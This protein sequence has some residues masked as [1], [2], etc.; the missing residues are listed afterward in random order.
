MENRETKKLTIEGHEFVVKTYA[1][2]REANAIQQ[3]Y[4]KDSKVEI[5][6]EQPK[7]SDFNPFVRFDVERELVNQ[8]VVSLDGDETNI[9][10]R[11][12]DMPSAIYRELVD[13]LDTLVAK[14]N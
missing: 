3:T 14:K 1:T 5:V 12:L 4:L 13:E 7:I 10:E 8:L 2:A 11:C 9:I 6:G